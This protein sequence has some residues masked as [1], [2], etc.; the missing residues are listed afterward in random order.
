MI[1]RPPRSTLFPYTT[2]FRSLPRAADLLSLGGDLSARGAA[3]SPGGA[4]ATRSAH[5]WRRRG[6]RSAD[7]EDAFRRRV[8]RCG[9][10]GG[11]GP[12]RGLRGVAVLENRGV[13]RS[14]SPHSSLPNAQMFTGVRSF[15][16]R[17]RAPAS[18]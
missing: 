10:R 12:V 9:A 8:R 4:H 7:R 17:P 3:P 5:L 16:P 11:G 13:T 1:R 2:L 15:I 18:G 6:A 14:F